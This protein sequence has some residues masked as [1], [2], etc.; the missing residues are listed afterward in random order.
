MHI[1]LEGVRSDRLRILH[2]HVVLDSV[3]LVGQVTPDD[4]PRP[5]PCADWALADLLAHMTAQHRG[6]AAAALGDGRSRGRW[7]PRPAED[8]LAHYGDTA[9]QVIAAFGLV[10]AA[11][12][13]LSIPDISPD[14]TFSADQ[15]VAF[16]LVDYVAHSWDVARSLGI[17][18]DPGPDVL[19][20]AL[21]I[22]TGIPDGGSRL[23]VD[24]PFGP[25]LVPAA[26][27]SSLDRFLMALG[28]SPD[29]RPGAPHRASAD[30]AHGTA[31]GDPTC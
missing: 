17:P 28:R 23:A 14:R 20:A 22:A 29:W 4:L 2:A 30:A 19:R 15:A 13:G 26:E 21:P 24:S 9:D 8:A 31:V 18:Y 16:H 27:A 12:R 11:D 25:G 7:E 1:N 10:A 5:T 6:F 3:R